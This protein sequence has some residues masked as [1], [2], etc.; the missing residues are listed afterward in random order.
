[1]IFGKICHIWVDQIIVDGS[2]AVDELLVVYLPLD[3]NDCL[4]SRD[5]LYC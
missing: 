4:L 2:K 3:L 1:M 5:L